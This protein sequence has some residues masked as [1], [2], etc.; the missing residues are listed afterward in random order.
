MK[1]HL[2]VEKVQ[3][4]SESDKEES[5]EEPSKSKSKQVMGQNDKSWL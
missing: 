1:M 5:K 2:K 4:A 3:Q